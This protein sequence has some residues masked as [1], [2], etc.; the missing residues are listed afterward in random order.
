[1]EAALRCGAQASHGGGF[2]CC[3]AWALGMWASVVAACGLSSCGSQ[4]LECR[5]SSGGTQAYLLCGMW[6]LPRPGIE[7]MSLKMAGGFLTTAP[8][9]KSPVS[10]LDLELFQRL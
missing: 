1:M 2:S 9:G 6:D 3:G 7:P 8:P 4:V 5:L 10:H